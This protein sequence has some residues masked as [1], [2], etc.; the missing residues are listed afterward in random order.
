MKKHL[1]TAFSL[2][3]FMGPVALAQDS[4]SVEWLS[5]LNQAT[6]LAAETG[7]PLLVVFR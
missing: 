2:A 5:D 7:R 4:E 3:A 1:S 6:E